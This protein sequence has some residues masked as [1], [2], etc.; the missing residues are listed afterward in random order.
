[1]QRNPVSKSKQ[2]NKQTNQNTQ[3]AKQNKKCQVIINISYGQLVPRINSV[4]DGKILAKQ[5]IL[6]LEMNYR[7]FGK[8]SPVSQNARAVAKGSR[9]LF[10]SLL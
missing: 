7:G 2:T 1:M 3:K 6:V 5:I 4:E 9:G 8:L 10:S